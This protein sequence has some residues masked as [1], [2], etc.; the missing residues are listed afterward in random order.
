MGCV[1]WSNLSQDSCSL[2]ED[3]CKHCVQLSVLFQV[4]HTHLEM[5]YESPSSYIQGHVVNVYHVT[6]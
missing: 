2:Q 5:N 1:N 3:A 6:C 4:D